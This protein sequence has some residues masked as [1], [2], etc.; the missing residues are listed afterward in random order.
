MKKMVRRIAAL[1]CI[2]TLFAAPATAFANT[3]DYIYEDP[4]TGYKYFSYASDPIIINPG[5]ANLL[6]NNDYSGYFYA[7]AGEVATFYISFVLVGD[8]R[9]I[10]HQLGGSSGTLVDEVFFTDGI[11]IG[12][13]ITETGLYGL[14][15]SPASNVS[16]IIDA[17]AI[18]R[19][20][21]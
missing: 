6:R 15:V 3:P 8:F 10:I 16:A 12:V 13:P 5:Y 14:I 20:K 21:Y 11:S 9:F 1:V 17:Y 4:I 2:M 7:E 18:F 19:D